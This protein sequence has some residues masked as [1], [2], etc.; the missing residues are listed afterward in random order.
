MSA[1]APIT[2]KEALQVR[3]DS[4]HHETSFFKRFIHACVCSVAN[5]SASPDA[6]HHVQQH[7]DGIGEIYLRS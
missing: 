2:V 1:V 5:Q 6:T 7:D 4:V 3:V